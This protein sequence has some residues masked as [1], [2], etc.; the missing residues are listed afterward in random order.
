M[1][2]T[3]PERR[4]PRRAALVVLPLVAAAVLAGGYLYGPTLLERVQPKPEPKPVT[5]D[6]KKLPRTPSVVAG[7]TGGEVIAVDPHKIA[8]K[9]AQAAPKPKAPSASTVARANP[10]LETKAQ[11]PAAPRARTQTPAASSTPTQPKAAVQEPSASNPATT[12][13]A[14]MTREL[15]LIQSGERMFGEDV[16]RVQ[17]RLMQLTGDDIARGGDGWFGPR[18]ERGVKQFQERAGLPVTGVVDA[19]TWKALFGTNASR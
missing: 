18:T 5:V 13:P 11:T 17:I 1:N 8:G 7:P 2:V 12:R 16:R 4:S 3:L 6:L 14:G 19:S 10:T 9:E 15:R